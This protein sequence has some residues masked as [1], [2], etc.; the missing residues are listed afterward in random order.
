MLP[1][2]VMVS[3]VTE[4]GGVGEAG[5]ACV[6]AGGWPRAPAAPAWLLFCSDGEGAACLLPN[7][8]GTS[9]F[10]QSQPLPPENPYIFRTENI[11]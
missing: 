10:C 3:V 5:V 8:D 7:L 9:C 2:A 6:E 11:L 1:D 4:A